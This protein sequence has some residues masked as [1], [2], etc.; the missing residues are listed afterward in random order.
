MRLRGKD[1]GTRKNIPYGQA[2]PEVLTSTTDLSPNTYLPMA[3][4]SLTI[5]KKSKKNAILLS[6]SL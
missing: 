1:A 2:M 5:Q 4:L 6:V 3:Y